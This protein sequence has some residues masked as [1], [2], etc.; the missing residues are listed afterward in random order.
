M[1]HTKVIIDDT[2][3]RIILAMFKYRNTKDLG[4]EEMVSRVFPDFHS[5]YERNKGWII[6]RYHLNKMVSYGFMFYEEDSGW[7]L[8]KE[9][10]FIKKH[11]FPDSK[12][13][14]SLFLKINN[15]WNIYEI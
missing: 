3:R 13:K 11:K 2:D 1:V 6:I 14:N 12:I 10:C 15:K 4:Y 8:H 5:K 9:Y 7:F